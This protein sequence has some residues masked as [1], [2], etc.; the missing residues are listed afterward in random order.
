M[1]LTFDPKA[2]ARVLLDVRAGGPRPAGLPSTPS[3][4]TAACAVQSEGIRRL[5]GRAC[6]KMALLAGRDRHAAAMPASDVAASGSTLGPMPHD[7]AIEIETAFIL[8]TDLPAGS[9]AG[10]ALAAIAEDRLAFE[11][12]SSRYRDRASVPPLEAMTDCFSSAAIV[13]GNLILDWRSRLEE[14]LELALSLNGQ[15]E[16]APEQTPPLSETAD[17]LA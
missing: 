8:G 3:D 9:T 13:L 1:S 12:V 6:W 15:H 16:I 14:P 7:A 10:A 4:T 2:A 11:I 17:F 5:G